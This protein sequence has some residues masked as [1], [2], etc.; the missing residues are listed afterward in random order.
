MRSPTNLAHS[1]D[2]EKCPKTRLLDAPV[3]VFQ[4]KRGA[5]L[6]SNHC[7][8]RWP[9]GLA[10]GCRPPLNK[11]A[12]GGGRRSYATRRS[13]FLEGP[14]TPP[15]RQRLPRRQRAVP[16]VPPATHSKLP[17]PEQSSDAA[18]RCAAQNPTTK[19]RTRPCP[20]NP[21]PNEATARSSP[22]NARAIPSANTP[23]AQHLPPTSTT[24]SP[25]T[26]AA[27]PTGTTCNPTAPHTPHA[28]RP[29]TRGWDSAPR[30]HTTVD[31]EVSSFSQTVLGQRHV[32]SKGWGV[33]PHRPPRP[34][35]RG[36]FVDACSEF[37][38]FFRP[39]ERTLR[40]AVL[41]CPAQLKIL[42]G[43]ARAATAVAGRFPRRRSSFVTAP[44]PPDWPDAE[45][46]AEWHR[47]APGLEALD[48]LKP[49]D[50]AALAVFCETWSRFVAAVRLYRAEGMVLT[51]PDSG[52]LRRHPAVGIAEA[53]DAPNCV[54]SPPSSV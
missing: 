39:L 42:K 51:N 25:S 28:D 23:P 22:S 54:R 47:V 26:K 49:E 30:P 29:H 20:P 16:F 52:N 19:L 41:P 53:T 5:S 14:P 21:K 17:T 4:F 7:R 2:W 48:I 6:L 27:T 37:Q 34:L 33:D 45:S 32:R 1:K 8:V 44:G 11:R 43:R 38:P 9:T 12:L 46:L 31:A 24:S 50:R 3:R 35:R 18:P 40:W 13:P 36:G 10:Y 15:T